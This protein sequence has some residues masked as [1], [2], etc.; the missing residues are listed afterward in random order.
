MTKKV[1]VVGNKPYSNFKL[2]KIAD[3]FDITYRCNFARPDHNNGTKFG[4]LAMCCHIY[5]NFVRNPASKKKMMEIYSD[6]FDTTFLNDW[7]D[8]YQLNK[9]RFEEIFYQQPE[10]SQW[11]KMLDGYGCPHRFTKEPRTGYSAVFRAL[12][13]EPNNEVYVMSFS[14]AGDEYRKSRGVKEKT[15][16]AEGHGCHSMSDEI[17]ILSWLHN[18]KTV[19]ASLC[20]LNDTKELNI[21][22]DKYMKPSEFILDLIDKNI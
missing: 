18:N 20:M 6:E 8:F 19:D 4:R 5:E 22:A 13:D 15:A 21:Q 2:N 11:N 10:A 16:R 1:L 7:F 17:N 3:S 9:T 12:R 14:L